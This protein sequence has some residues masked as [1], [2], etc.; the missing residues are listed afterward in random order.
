MPKKQPAPKKKTEEDTDKSFTFDARPASLGQVSHVDTRIVKLGT[1]RTID[2][3]S[4]D[5]TAWPMPV[6]KAP[7]YA[8]KRAVEMAKFQRE[9]KKSGLEGFEPA[10]LA[11]A[12]LH[13]TV[14]KTLPDPLNEVKYLRSTLT[15]KNTLTNIEPS[16]K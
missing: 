13:S 12:A 6:S 8:K 7:K 1:K 10:E 15:N 16:R 9:A 3:D 4:E 2:V 11:A 5:E 14:I